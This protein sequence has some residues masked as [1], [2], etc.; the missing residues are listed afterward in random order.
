MI[1]LE[2]TILFY[3]Y[4]INNYRLIIFYI[5]FMVEANVEKAF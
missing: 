4:K 5:R 2:I 3:L 1:Y